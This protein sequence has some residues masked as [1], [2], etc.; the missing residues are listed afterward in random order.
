M[1]MRCPYC[2]FAG[3]RP[4]IHLH[5]AEAHA[6]RLAFSWHERSG[7]AIATVRC[8]LCGASWDQPLRKARR[9]PGFL[10]EYAYEIRLVLFDLL[11]HHIRGEHETEGEA[12]DG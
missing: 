12:R 1:S 4:T 5:L 9:D 11:L 7:Y 3:D 10:D 8:P 6:D 2:D